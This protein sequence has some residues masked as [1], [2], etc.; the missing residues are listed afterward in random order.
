MLRDTGEDSVEDEA[1]L[2]PTLAEEESLD[3]DLMGSGE[4]FCPFGD[5]EVEPLLTEAS[6]GFE[7]EAELFESLGDLVEAG[8]AGDDSSELCLSCFPLDDWLDEEELWWSAAV[9]STSSTISS[10]VTKSSRLKFCSSKN[11]S[12]ETSPLKSS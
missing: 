11:L 1:E 10:T 3:W 12:V 2:L 8:L 5:K 9:S 4:T 6:S 7:E